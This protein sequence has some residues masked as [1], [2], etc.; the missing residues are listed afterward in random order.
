[1]ERKTKYENH[2]PLHISYRRR[3]QSR[4]NIVCLAHQVCRFRSLCAFFFPFFFYQ[5]THSMRWCVGRDIAAQ[6]AYFRWILACCADS[7]FLCVCLNGK[8]R[9]WLS[10]PP[11]TTAGNCSANIVDLSGQEIHIIYYVDSMA[12]NRFLFSGEIIWCV[13]VCEWAVLSIRAGGWILTFS[14]AIM[15]LGTNRGFV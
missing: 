12:L 1:M 9:K 10:S 13:R 15:V 7:V 14:L 3:W 2:L 5:N 6:F 4:Y 11:P 8:K